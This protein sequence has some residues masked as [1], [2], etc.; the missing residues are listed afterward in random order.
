MISVISP[1]NRCFFEQ[2]RNY[3]P[4]LGRI[5]AEGIV[6]GFDYANLVA[7][8]E[9]AQLLQALGA[10]QRAD[11][12]AGVFE[13]EVAAIDVEADMLEVGGPVRRVAPIWDRSARKIDRV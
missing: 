2:F 7:V 3:L 9:G 1:R 8:F 13:E 12:E 5:D 4:I 11:G 10:F 6:S